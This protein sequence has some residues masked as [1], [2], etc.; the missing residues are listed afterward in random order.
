LSELT[1]PETLLS[2]HAIELPAETS[3]ILRIFG[4][5]TLWL[6]ID[7]GA[8]RL[9][10]MLAGLFLIRYFGP[11]SFGIYSMALAV[12]WLANAVIDLGLTRYAARAVA[13]T[14]EEVRP[15]LALSL[16]STVAAAL[17]TIA[18]LLVGSRLAQVQLACLTAGFILC[19]LEG[20]SSLCSSIL[21]ADLR[22]RDILPGSILGAAGLIGLTALTIWQHLSPLALLVGL[23][24]KSLVVLCLRLWQLRSYWP[25]SE[26]WSWRSCRRV[27]GQA[28][29]FFANN[30]TQVA[31]GKA[32]IVCL[33]FIAAK[34]S[35]G[36]FAAAYTISDVIPQW[37]Y[38][39]SGALLPVW[40]RLYETGRIEDLL[41]L[42]QRLLDV[43]LFAS[44]PIWIS[45]AAFSRPVCSALGSQYLPSVPVLRIVA[46]RSV[47]AV[48]DGFLG[49]GFLVAVD[50]V[51]ERQLALWRCLILLTTLSSLLGYIWGANGVAV[52]L[53]VSDGTLILQYLWIA[54]RIGLK[55]HWPGITPSLVAAAF[56]VL[57][58]LGLPGD[59]NP[60][61]RG[62]AALVVYLV[63]LVVLFRNRVLCLGQTL[64][65]CFE[66]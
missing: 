9:G 10:T 16:L 33:G 66:S 61:F 60:I 59:I 41:N 27:A 43:I 34:A 1:K 48:L 35:V 42:R 23:S 58:A 64:R 30:L 57:C 63:V 26:D 31:Y 25:A 39:V 29:P 54:S 22:S 21:T 49:H 40:T 5:N 4:R 18:V 24:F 8:L 46:L 45:L 7:L 14:R 11:N 32:P 3:G 50:R 52:A 38:A 15:I 56:M 65:E 51:K 20:T 47:L 17:P 53:V 6:W 13:A 12:G 19:N 55:I 2:S 36:W 28:W 62:L 37:S 44:I